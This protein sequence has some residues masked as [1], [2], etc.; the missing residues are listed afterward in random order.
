MTV[1]PST[2]HEGSLN[3]LMRI[4]MMH[5]MQFSNQTVTWLKLCRY[6][7][8][9]SNIVSGICVLVQAVPKLTIY[10]DI[11]S[12]QSTGLYR[13]WCDKQEKHSV[14]CSRVRAATTPGVSNVKNHSLTTT[15]SRK[16]SQAAIHQGVKSTTVE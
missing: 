5:V 14:P 12:Q 10:W 1:A 3:D 7:L 6:N 11:R 2:G 16:A 15:A 4:K 13:E 9:A 8:R